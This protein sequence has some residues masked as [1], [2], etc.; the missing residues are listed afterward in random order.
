MAALSFDHGID[1]I[2]GLYMGF[3][4]LQNSW[5]DVL[6][7]EHRITDY[8]IQ[9]FLRVLRQ[10]KILE[11]LPSFCI[12]WILHSQRPLFDQIR[13]ALRLQALDQLHQEDY[14]VGQLRVAVVPCFH[15]KLTVTHGPHVLLLF[16][17]L[18]VSELVG[19]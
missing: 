2:Y 13:V 17:T 3:G 18:L 11:L 9:Q 4:H 5:H 6:V 19:N 14:E 15:G 16:L 10:L 7:D 8:Q 1:R 12:F